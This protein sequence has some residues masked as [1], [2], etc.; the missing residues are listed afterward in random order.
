MKLFVG[1]LDFS[2]QESEL[3][4]LFSLHGTPDAV[5][6]VIDRKTGKS[7]GFAFVEFENDVHAVKSI[8]DL[9]GREVNGRKISV[10]EA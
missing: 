7:K 6:I 5:K 10:K 4:E 1:N 9:D 3:R 8:Q 2:V